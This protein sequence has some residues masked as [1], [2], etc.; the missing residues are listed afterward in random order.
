M[1]QWQ[2]NQLQKNLQSAHSTHSV[3]N[4]AVHMQRSMHLLFILPG[5]ILIHGI[6]L[7]LIGADR[8]LG[9]TSEFLIYGHAQQRRA[10]IEA[11]RLL[12]T[13]GNDGQNLDASKHDHDSGDVNSAQQFKDK[14]KKW[15]KF[16]TQVSD[17]TSILFIILFYS[18]NKKP[19]WIIWSCLFLLFKYLL[20]CSS[21][22]KDLH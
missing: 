18:H 5:I 7:Q 13:G 8:R 21:W 16:V 20:R 1:E 10:I 17:A 22:L 15:Q 19:M 3:Y 4:F 9:R 14:S 11:V 12:E 2:G 6:I